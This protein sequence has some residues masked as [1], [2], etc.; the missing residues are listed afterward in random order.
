M[1]CN[2]QYS[3]TINLFL[4]KNIHSCRAAAIAAV[5]GA[6]NPRPNEVGLRGRPAGPGCSGAA[7]EFHCYFMITAYYILLHYE[8]IVI[9]HCYTWLLHITTFHSFITLYYFILITTLLL[10]DYYMITTQLL[11]DYL[12]TPCHY[13]TVSF[14]RNYCA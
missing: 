3:V 7:A 14:E 2:Q 10:H 12:L 11:H 4:W 1:N 6:R 9:A 13:F 5:T 8:L